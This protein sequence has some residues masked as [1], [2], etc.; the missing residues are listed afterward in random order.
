M[1]TIISRDVAI[2]NHSIDNGLE[3]LNVDIDE[4]NGL[5]RKSQN[6]DY[7]HSHV[8]GFEKNNNPKIQEFLKNYNTI[9]NQQNGIYPKKVK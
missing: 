1:L 7:H 9:I 6:W 5:F 8:V 4:L 2:Y 3:P